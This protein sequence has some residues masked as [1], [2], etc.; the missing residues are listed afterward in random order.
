MWKT[1]KQKSVSAKRAFVIGGVAGSLSLLALQFVPG[2]ARSNPPVV[3]EHTLQISRAVPAHVDAILRRSCMNCHSNETRWPWYSRVAPLSWGIAND[4]ARA[5]KAMN[6][7]EWTRQAGKHPGTAMGYLNAMCAG[8]K[9]ERMPPA[10]YVMLHR[11]ARLSASDRQS[12]CAWTAAESK[13]YIEM[14]RSV[15]LT[16]R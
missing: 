5:R 9:G 6:F 13:R 8:V 3:Q 7:S 1:T 16:R 2:P 4:V 11:E 12:L 10:K 15:L 14:K